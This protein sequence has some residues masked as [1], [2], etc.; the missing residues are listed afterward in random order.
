MRNDVYKMAVCFSEKGKDVIE[1]LNNAA[2]QAGVSKAEPY[3]CYAGAGEAS[4]GDPG[5]GFR[6][7]SLDEYTRIGFE[8]H[9]PLIFV[10]ATGIAVRAISAYVK[11]KLTDTPVIVIDDNGRFV[12]PILSGHAGGANK[13]AVIIANLLDAIPVITTSTD[14]NRAFSADVFA[15]ENH[16]TIRNREGI[17]KVSAK[18]I[19]GKP[20]TLSVKDYPPRE[21]VDIILADRTDSEYDLLLSPKKYTIGIGTRK[22]KDPEEAEAFILE[23]LAG[24]GIAVQDVYAVC[25]V[26]IKEDEP[27]IKRFCGKYSLPLITFEASLLERVQGDFTASRFVKKTVGVD[28]VC[29]RAAFLGALPDAKLI[30]RKTSGEGITVAICQRGKGT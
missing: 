23:V 9:R 20:V 30:L 17:R 10:G 29:E 7:I 11:D 14:V 12:I 28:N 24:E 25:T 4:D 2:L 18:A 21:K 22:G 3:K 16:L 13:L 1:R 8:S 6:S 26:D 5:D 19:E 27:A 15:V